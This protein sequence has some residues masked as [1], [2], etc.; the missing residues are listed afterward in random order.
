MHEIYTTMVT[1]DVL[2]L[3]DA[4]AS[5]SISSICCE[6]VVQKVAQQIHNKS[7]QWSLNSNGQTD[8]GF[9]HSTHTRRL[10]IAVRFI[11][12]RQTFRIYRKMTH[13]FLCNYFTT[14][15]A[16]FEVILALM[17]AS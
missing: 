8:P 11:Q 3:R 2:R 6:F 4:Q 10:V 5:Y 13:S 17:L 16:T 15:T 14:A 7:K 12:G 1:A 9:V